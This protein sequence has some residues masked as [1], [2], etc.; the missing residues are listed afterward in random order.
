MEINKRINKKNLFFEYKQFGPKLSELKIALCENCPKLDLPDKFRSY[1]E[2]H[3]LK[4]YENGKQ[5]DYDGTLVAP[6]NIRQF[7]NRTVIECIPYSYGLHA[8]RRSKYVDIKDDVETH[9][10]NFKN[11]VI[12]KNDSYF[13]TE[14]WPLPLGVECSII[15]K[16]KK[17]V[18]TK[19]SSDH[20]TSIGLYSNACAGYYELQDI[21]SRLP[22]IK[23]IL[24]EELKEELNLGYHNFSSFEI[25]TMV[26]S[27]RTYTVDLIIVGILNEAITDLKKHFSDLKYDN[28]LEI[29]TKDNEHILVDLK[30]IEILA[31]SGYSKVNNEYLQTTDTLCSVLKN[32]DIL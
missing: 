18:I 10:I 29:Y 25:L 19:R 24:I 28:G 32:K 13:D 17:M 23:S 31:S 20:L 30:N 8:L 14:I 15:T 26:S 3:N 16:N 1:F 11:K 7:K 5:P 6:V 2:L 4:K 21:Q 12:N 22:T 9:L 27:S